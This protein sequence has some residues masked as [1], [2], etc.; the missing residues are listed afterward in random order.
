MGSPIDHYYRPG[1]LIKRRSPSALNYCISRNVEKDWIQTNE[2]K[3]ERKRKV[4]WVH[5]CACISL[6]LFWKDIQIQ[7]RKS[8]VITTTFFILSFL[9]YFPLPDL[10]LARFNFPFGEIWFLQRW[11]GLL[12]LLRI[13]MF[14]KK[15][16]ALKLRCG[17]SQN[18][19]LGVI[20]SLVSLR[21]THLK[22]EG[23]SAP[24]YIRRHFVPMLFCNVRGV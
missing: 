2:K 13:T 17:W 5:F 19:F 6:V 24:S 8:R 21:W 9:S 14:I 16:R 20:W 15:K 23:F 22:K 7:R 1:S 4:R 11:M 10:P 12:W 3:S 18:F